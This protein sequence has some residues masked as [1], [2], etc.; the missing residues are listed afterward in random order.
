MDYLGFFYEEEAFSYR[1]SH[2]IYLASLQSDYWK[3]TKAIQIEFLVIQI[4]LL[5]WIIWI[6]VPII[7]I[8]LATFGHRRQPYLLRGG[9]INPLYFIGSDIVHS[10]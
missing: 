3:R 9:T 2:A 8:L 6:I 4:N 1:L 5:G 7:G 10:D